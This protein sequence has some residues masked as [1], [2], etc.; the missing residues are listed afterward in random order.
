M[1]QF[2]QADENE[3]M[4]VLGLAGI[5]SG[6]VGGVI[7]A[8]MHRRAVRKQEAAS[9][10]GS[11]ASLL[12]SAKGAANQSLSQA[13]GRPPQS[14]QDWSAAAERLKGQAA[15]SANRG[16]KLSK[17]HMRKMDV[18]EF[19]DRARSSIPTAEWADRIDKLGKQ[20]RSAASDG[21]KRSRKQLG[22]VDLESLTRKGRRSGSEIASEI[23]S[24]ASAL[25]EV[26]TDHSDDIADVVKQQ[27]RQALARADDVLAEA[28]S[29]GEQL[30][31]HAK[32]RTPEFLDAAE[33]SIV[34]RARELRENAMPLIGSAT[35]ALA[36][37]IETGKELALDTKRS[38]DR[39]LVPA[40][41]E[42]AG[43]ASE[44]IDQVS[45]QAS[46]A[47]SGI[48]ETMDQRSREVAQAAAQG[49]R[50]SGAVAAWSVVAGGVI[51]YGFLD[52]E[53]R[54]KLKAAGIRIAREAREIYRDIQSADDA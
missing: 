29:R 10:S 25:A 2:P 49:T 19:Y 6:I 44:S 30:V 37:G 34:P 31:E 13:V 7:A 48:S 24:G 20:A 40:L 5:S 42:R 41:K 32:D 27:T 22:A 33:R 35:A 47:W 16:R 39:E 36:S 54:E 1:S 9:R 21:R 12:D 14:K 38:A 52:E 11:M 53:Q 51:F 17:E 46:E 43:A 3:N 45:S 26:A 15:A 4:Q 23:A 8:L 18:D 28:K 50:N